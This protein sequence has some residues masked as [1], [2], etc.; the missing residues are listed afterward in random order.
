MNKHGISLVAL[1]VTVVVLVIL[2]AAIVAPTS[3]NKN[4][5][6]ETSNVVNNYNKLTLINEIRETIETESLKKFNSNG[7][8]HLTNSELASIMKDFGTFNESTLELYIS[9][10][11]QLNLIEI[12]PKVINNYMQ[13]SIRDNNLTITSSLLSVGYTFEYSLDNQATWTTYS[14]PITLTE[15]SQV[16]IRITSTTGTVVAITNI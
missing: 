8:I 6:G 11:P 7:S 9:N 16:Y 1:I 12:Y 10:G 4:V 3:D 5:L 15:N 2:T 14:S 13:T